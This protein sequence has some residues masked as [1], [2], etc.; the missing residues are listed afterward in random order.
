MTAE[1]I[2]NRGKMRVCGATG[3]GLMMLCMRLNV[4]N[5]LSICTMEAR[6]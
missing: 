5:V 4:G 1:S 2:L 6:R 3:G